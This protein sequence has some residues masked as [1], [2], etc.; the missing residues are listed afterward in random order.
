MAID[1]TLSDLSCASCVGRAERALGAVPGVTRASVNLATG[2]A[3]VEGDADPAALTAALAGAGYPA[4]ETVV[5]LD[6]SGMSCA[7]CTG[8]VERALAARP[9]VLSAEANFATGTARVRVLEGAAT[10]AEL[11]RAATEAGYAATP[12]AADAP[13][14]DRAAEAD[15]L[16]RRTLIAAALT[17]PVFVVEMGGHLIPALHM[18]IHSV[19]DPRVNGLAQLVLT[20]LVMFGPG[21]GFYRHGLPALLRGAPEMN[22]LVALGTLAAWGYSTVA[23]VAPGLFP[24]GTAA[25]YFEPA[26]VIVTLILLGRWLEARARGRTGAA[27][28]RL[29]GLAPRTALRLRDGAAEEVPLEAVA[30]G[31]LLE[32]R[33]GARVPVDGV[34]VEGASFVDESMVTGEPVPVEK[35]AG[36]PLTGGTVNGAGALVMR[37]E[38]VGGDTVLAQIVR[39]V[40]EAQGAKLPIQALV[41]RVT[42]VF[43]PVVLAVAL[44]TLGAW[45][46]FAPSLALV[47]AVSVLIV[48]CPCAMGLATPTSIM[49]G[50]GRAA[51]LGVLFR[52]GDA[53]QSLQGAA[54]VAFDKT[55]TLT[56]GRPELTA[57]EPVAGVARAE[58]LALAAAV[59]ARSEHPIARAI[60]RAAEAE[61]LDVAQAE[62]FAATPGMGA[63]ARVGGRDVIV[64]ADRFLLAEGVELGPVRAAGARIA[65]GG[66]T[67]LYLAADGRALAAIGVD[68]PVKPEARAT[69]AA[70]KAQGL[71]VALVTGDNAATARAVADRLGI[72][73]VL[74]EVMPGGKADAVRALRAAHGP[75][76]FVGDGINDAPALAEAD[77]GVAI[78]TGTDVAIEAADVVLM[79]GD[80]AG[81]VRALEVSRATIRNVRQNLFWA[82]AYNTALI[83][84][85]AGVLYPATG[86]LLSPML[87]AG[88]M[89]LSSVFVLANALRLRRA[90]GR[91]EAP[92]PRA[93]AA[94]TPAAAGLAPG[95]RA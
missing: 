49:V 65:E 89:A 16:R 81:V 32:L 30:P 95:G 73:V 88:A 79:S 35:A 27:I 61:G 26:A 78:G 85:A 70:L 23:L 63:R 74:A 47:A 76:A 69:V 38:A 72:D 1:L 4:R 43:V 17:L 29:A 68:D 21:I 39:M 77:V 93:G 84:V 94:P 8:R 50:T 51:E 33:P 66:R 18:V 5:V 90:A 71:R 44:V 60:L 86:T 83:P 40:E 54:V 37:A 24:E 80:P 56:A 46:W 91:A 34:A 82:F 53:L 87:A 3:R 55:G 7:S 10:A 25:L 64:G 92:G 14:P 11:A 52:R 15:A 12:H 13:G 45:L 2:R 75:V 6:V 41:D 59:E 67:P 28:A 36:A 58:A 62:G 48:A 22:S 20:T 19:L 9:G 31:D 57:F 42:A